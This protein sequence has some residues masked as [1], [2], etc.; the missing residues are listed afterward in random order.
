MLAS[1][2]LLLN[3]N[4]RY[5]SGSSSL[6]V[7]QEKFYSSVGSGLAFP[8]F[9]PFYETFNEKISRMIEGGLI[10]LWIQN[11]FKQR[12]VNKKLN[13]IGPEILTMEHLDVAFKIILIALAISVIG[14]LSEIIFKRLKMTFEK[15][16]LR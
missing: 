12:G 13:D 11:A 2:F 8:L 10:N 9:S 3:I 15:I 5:R 14:F 7:L 4:S 16:K 6:L 1:Y